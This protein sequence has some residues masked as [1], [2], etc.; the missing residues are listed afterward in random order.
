M[1]VIPSFRPTPE[2]FISC[3][4]S[5]PF[6]RHYRLQKIISHRK[7]VREIRKLRG[8]KRNF[9][10]LTLD[11][12]SVG[13]KFR[14][15]EDARLNIRFRNGPVSQIFFYARFVVAATVVL[16]VGKWCVAKLL[17]NGAATLCQNGVELWNY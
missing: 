4:R 5:K 6:Y 9:P 13:I 17:R 2:G 3:K 10:S 15:R 1:K 16:V 8:R 7:R 11:Y 14:L 12:I